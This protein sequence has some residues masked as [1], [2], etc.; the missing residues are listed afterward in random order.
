MTIELVDGKTYVSE[1]GLRA[2]IGGTTKYFPDWVWSI[3]GDWYVRATGERL[4]YGQLG[5][6]TDRKP[7]WGHKVM[8][9]ER[10]LHLVRED[11]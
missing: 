5:L 11:V 4:A 7:L 1:R 6:D 9:A 10:G 8:A 3:Q 2:T